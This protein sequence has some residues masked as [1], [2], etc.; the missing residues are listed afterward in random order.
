MKVL[1]LCSE[2]PDHKKGFKNLCNFAKEKTL[3]ESEWIANYCQE[4]NL[5]Q[6]NVLREKY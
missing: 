3:K 5:S 1:V 4:L 6:A 2:N